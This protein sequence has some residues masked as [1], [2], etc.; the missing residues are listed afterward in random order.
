MEGEIG[1][2][3]GAIWLAL[4]GN[5]GATLP[6]LKKKIEC[7]PPVFDWAIGWLARENKIA[8]TRDR[9]SFVVKLKDTPN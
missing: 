1:D 7:K 2:V 3:A 8:I 6:E 9:R 5:G 4:S